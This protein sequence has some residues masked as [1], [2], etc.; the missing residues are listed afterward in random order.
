MKVR[1][2][3]KQTIVDRIQECHRRGVPVGLIW[4][5]DR[6]MTSSAAALFGSW[7]AALEAAGLESVRR[8]WSAECVLQELR[9]RYRLH[10]RAGIRQGT[11][12]V[13]A[14]NRYFG[15][16]GGAM[17]AAGLP[18]R[19]PRVLRRWDHATVLDALRD[20]QEQGLPLS[21]LRH[22]DA[23]LYVAAARYFGSWR[24][25][26]AAIGVHVP[27]QRRLTH[28]QLLAELRAEYEPPGGQPRSLARLKR[29]RSPAS[30][31]FGSWES[32]LKA[33]GLDHHIATR[34]SRQRIIA[35]IRD[36]QRE[37]RPLTSV[38]RSDKP[39]FRAGIRYFG[40]WQSAL[41]AA[42]MPVKQRDRWSR[43]QVIGALQRTYSGN[44]RLRDLEPALCGAIQ[45][46]FQSWT[47]ALEAAGLEPPPHRWTRERIIARI[48]HNYVA[49]QSMLFSK[50]LPF[51]YTAKRHFGSWEAALGAAGL[52][53]VVRPRPPVRHWSAELV[54]AAVRDL[55]DQSPNHVGVDRID[56][57]L[58]GA[59]RKH[60]GSWRAAMLAAGRT[61]GR[62]RWSREAV[63]DAIVERR[64]RGLP[65]SSVVFKDDPPLAG[66]ATRL[67][68][69]WRQAVGAAESWSSPA[70]LTS[71]PSR[72][73]RNEDV[74]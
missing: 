32:A 6:K 48:Q 74:A 21:T 14:A 30:S 37:G 5:E 2:W 23:G 39:L 66:A 55:C 4:R 29:L 73:E 1:K 36:Y 25:A 13:A 61:P 47:E 34:W 11:P 16:L 41:A 38:W 33:A 67:F 24:K 18:A 31:I 43:D 50:Q 60:F 65:L 53:R 72:S 71:V 58:Q 52:E 28:E 56:Y 57:G 62:R 68:G 42:G 9:D 15:S 59:A 45:R 69:G 51:A 63:L 26:L 64:Q 44:E 22:D 3:H 19:P 27:P 49:G 10:G 20:R 17:A 46:H 12:L 54:I 35:C 70:V 40:N 8:R 7:R